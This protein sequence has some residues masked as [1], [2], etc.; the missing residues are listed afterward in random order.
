MAKEG[1]R[2]NIALR[3]FLM[4]FLFRSPPYLLSPFKAFASV[5]LHC[6]LA[7][8]SFISNFCHLCGMLRKLGSGLKSLPRQIL[9]NKEIVF[10]EP[11]NYK[12]IF[13]YLDLKYFVHIFL[14]TPSFPTLQMNT[15]HQKLM[16]SILNSTS[17]DYQALS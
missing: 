16:N 5:Y 1:F 9:I 15:H 2:F 4:E 7:S 8:Q 6:V 3:A 13:N 11:H 14:P 17:A 10:F 12:K